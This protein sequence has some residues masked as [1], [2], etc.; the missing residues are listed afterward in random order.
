[1]PIM[2]MTVPHL[3]MRNMKEEEDEPPQMRSECGRSN[4]DSSP[5]EFDDVVG[6]YALTPSPVESGSPPRICYLQTAN[7]GVGCCPRVR[8]RLAPKGMGTA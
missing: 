5:A 4:G 6:V 7:G 2:K 3:V 8:T 1:M